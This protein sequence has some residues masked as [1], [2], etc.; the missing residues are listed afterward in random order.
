MPY[1]SGDYPC[2]FNP[3]K[4]AQPRNLRELKPLDH[5][6]RHAVEPEAMSAAGLED[7]L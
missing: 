6:P 2:P 4:S 3:D 5:A 7:L 1:L